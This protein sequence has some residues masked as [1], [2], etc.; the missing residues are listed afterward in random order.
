MSSGVC[1]PG[2]GVLKWVS[3]APGCCKVVAWLVL[4]LKNKARTLRQLVK[5]AGY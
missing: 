5:P 4:S 3:K 1:C 2:F